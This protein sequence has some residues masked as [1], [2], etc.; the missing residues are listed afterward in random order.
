MQNGETVLLVF[1][2]LNYVLN[3]HFLKKWV[4]CASQQKEVNQKPV[5][6]AN[7][8]KDLAIL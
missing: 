8:V 7:R 6:H 1:H 4:L 2:I 3:F 5:H